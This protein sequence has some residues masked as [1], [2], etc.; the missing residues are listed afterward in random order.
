MGGSDLRT[1]AS[2]TTMIGSSRLRRQRHSKTAASRSIRPNRQ[3]ARE[4]SA[5]SSPRRSFSVIVTG[6]E[7]S[8][9]RKMRHPP[10]SQKY[11]CPCL[12]SFASG[13][14]ASRQH[15]EFWR[16]EGACRTG[17]LCRVFPGSPAPPVTSNAVRHGPGYPFIRPRSARRRR[18]LDGTGRSCRHSQRSAIIKLIN[19]GRAEM[20]LG[21]HTG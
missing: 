14:E 7:R 10:E 1:I 21:R 11:R 4:S 5:A 16:F 15:V 9:R 2:N 6:F 19:D 17:S 13:R 8:K 3:R 20:L 12:Y 18:K